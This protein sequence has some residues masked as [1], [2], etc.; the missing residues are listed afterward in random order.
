MAIRRTGNQSSLGLFSNPNVDYLFPPIIQDRDPNTSDI[1]E[2]GQTWVNNSASTFWVNVGSNSSG[3]IWLKMSSTGGAGSFS[4]VT[5]TN[6]ITST[7][8]NIIAT[9]GSLVA[10]TSVTAATGISTTTGDVTASD[11]NFVL[12]TA[13]TYVSLPGPVKIMSGAGAPAAGLAVEVGDVY[14]NTTAASATTRMYIATAA[15]TW[16]NVTCAA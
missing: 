3:S 8:G 5:A 13:G 10:G 9:D 7:T 11:G 16:T 1:V 15:G 12:S 14:I 2:N 6:N 4:S